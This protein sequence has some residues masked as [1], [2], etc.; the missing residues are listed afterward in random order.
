[1]DASLLSPEDLAILS[2]GTGIRAFAR[3]LAVTR[4]AGHQLDMQIHQVGGDY[5]LI[6]IEVEGE[7]IVAEH[8][9]PID[10]KGSAEVVRLSVL[11]IYTAQ[12][13][14]GAEKHRRRSEIELSRIRACRTDHGDVQAARPRRR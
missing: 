14:S 11:S 5:V 13:L 12:I 8:R 9:L 10:W 4:I 2:R 1:V 6:G 7:R 3:V